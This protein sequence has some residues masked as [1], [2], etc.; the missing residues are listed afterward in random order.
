M[1]LIDNYWID[2]AHA[3]QYLADR[4]Q[5]AQKATAAMST[6]CASVQTQWAGSED[7]EAVVGLDEQNSIRSVISLNPHSVKLI[8]SMSEAKLIDYLK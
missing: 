3:Q 1:V 4:S 6:F 7:G 5:A 2:D 8:L